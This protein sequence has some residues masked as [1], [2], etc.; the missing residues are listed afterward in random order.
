MPR[1]ARHG[2]HGLAVLRHCVRLAGRWYFAWH[3]P[4][5]W[6]AT[7]LNQPPIGPNKMRW[8]GT[9]W[10]AGNFHKLF[11]SFAEFWARAGDH[12]GRVAEPALLEKFI[13]RM[14]RGHAAPKVKVRAA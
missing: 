5:S 1:H 11:L 14:R 6:Y 3:L 10:V 7:D 13:A 12:G 4:L 8:P 2:C 9:P